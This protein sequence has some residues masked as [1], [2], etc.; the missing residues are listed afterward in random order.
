MAVCIAILEPVRMVGFGEHKLG[1]ILEWIGTEKEDDL[2]SAFTK[3][4]PVY[5]EEATC[6]AKD[7]ENACRFLAF[8]QDAILQ[9][10]LDTNPQEGQENTDARITTL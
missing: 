4:P 6:D 1:D 10:E 5:R 7:M 8:I 2:L 9:Y 3:W